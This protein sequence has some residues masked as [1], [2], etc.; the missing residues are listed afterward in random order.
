MSPGRD[1]R[2]VDRERCVSYF[3]LLW[4]SKKAL[5]PMAGRRKR[6]VRCSRKLRRS[7]AAVAT[8]REGHHQQRSGRAVPHPRWDPVLPPPH[9][10]AGLPANRQAPPPPLGMGIGNL[11]ELEAV[12]F[13]P[14]ANWS[15]PKGS[16]S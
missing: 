2:G 7:S 1:F 12:K 5:S 10:V 13:H 9:L 15:D 3:T 4:W 16:L 6:P 8:S 11:G 14:Q